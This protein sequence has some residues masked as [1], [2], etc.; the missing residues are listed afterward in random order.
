MPVE[1]LPGILAP[2]LGIAGRRRNPPLERLRRLVAP[3]EAKESTQ[4]RRAQRRVGR[5]LAQDPL[6]HRHQRV[7]PPELRIHALEPE[8]RLHLLRSLERLAVRQHGV[9]EFPRLLGVESPQQR[10]AQLLRA[11]GRRA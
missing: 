7:R 5:T 10:R 8:Y 9:V 2:R 6:E 11:E 4:L 3:P 1:Q